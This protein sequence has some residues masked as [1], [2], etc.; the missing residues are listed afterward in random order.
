MLFACMT[1]IFGESESAQEFLTNSRGNWALKL[2]KKLRTLPEK[3]VTGTQA[4]GSQDGPE[5]CPQLNSKAIH[6][7]QGEK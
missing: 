2:Q 1:G 6:L 7:G 4:A 3:I 5:A